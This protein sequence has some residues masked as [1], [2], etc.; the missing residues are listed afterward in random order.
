MKANPVLLVAF[1][2]LLLSGCGGKTY[3]KN[4]DTSRNLEQ[5]AA[6]CKSVAVGSVSMPN[7]QQYQ[8]NAAPYAP[9]SGTMVDQH[10]NTYRYQETYNPMA[11]AQSNM[12]MAQQ[13]FANAAVS[14]QNLASQLDV[15]N[16]R[17]AIANQCMAQLGWTQISKEEYDQ[18]QL[19]R[20]D[21]L[22]AMIQAAEQGDGWSSFLLAVAYGTGSV[23]GNKRVQQDPSQSIKWLQKSAEQGDINGQFHLGIMYRGGYDVVLAKDEYKAVELVR[24]A[25]ERGY[26]DGQRTLGEFYASGFG[27]VPKDGRKALEWF[28]KAA[29]QGDPLAQNMIGHV[30]NDGLGVPKNKKQA[31]EWYRKSIPG[32]RHKAEIGNAHA[33]Y[34][35]YFCLY[36]GLGVPKDTTEAVVWLKKA[37]EQGY[38]GAQEA[39]SKMKQAGHL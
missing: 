13:N 21:P 2:A 19:A 9:G 24:K 27:G 14:M 7:I 30:Y 3:Y 22:L 12:N 16:A 5:D 33:Q 20:K 39:L 11:A 4:M 31:T 23:I 6:Y 10:G 25:A 28:K 36:E 35:L 32:L 29:E 15:N 8:N 38:G 37:A 26:M 17:Q 1:T 34:L 18:R